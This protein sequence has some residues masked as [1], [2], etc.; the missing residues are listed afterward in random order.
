[1]GNILVAIGTWG[2]LC[3]ARTEDRGFSIG[4]AL[5]VCILSSF[6]FLICVSFVRGGLFIHWVCRE[7]V[8]TGHSAYVE[9]E[10]ERVY[11]GLMAS[12]PI[13]RDS[14]AAIVEKGFFCCEDRQLGVSYSE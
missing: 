5:T 4:W 13:L 2:A 1:M 6:P 14:S 9:A 11:S 12:H 10:R 3:I 8:S 7:H